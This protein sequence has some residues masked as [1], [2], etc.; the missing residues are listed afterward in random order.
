MPTGDISG[1][2]SALANA[3]Y[4]STGYTTDPTAYANYRSALRLPFSGEFYNGS[5]RNQGS[6]GYWWSSTRGSSSTWHMHAMYTVTNHIHPANTL[7]RSFGHS[8]RC[9]L[10][11]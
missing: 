4:G 10:G 2:Y 1:E 7:S 9:V 11:S 3:I 8:V 5:A 6:Y